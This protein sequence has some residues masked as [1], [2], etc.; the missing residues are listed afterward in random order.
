MKKGELFQELERLSG[1]RAPRW[2]A[3]TQL[4][5]TIGT[6]NEVWARVSGRKAREITF[7]GHQPNGRKADECVTIATVNRHSVFDFVLQKK[8]FRTPG[9]DIEKT[10]G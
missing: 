4:L 6:A 10:A 7:A 2:G 9:R 1:V 8:R 3:P 5:Y